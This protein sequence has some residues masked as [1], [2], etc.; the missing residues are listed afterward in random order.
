MI[1]IRPRRSALYMPGS[2]ARAIEKARTL[3]A[4]VVIFDL[5]DAVAPDLK[6]QAREQVCAA[7]K[8]GGYGRRELVIRVNALETPWGEADLAAAVA[9]APDAILVPKVSS[10]ETLAAVGLRLRKLGAA[11]R[12]GIWAMIE[13]PLAILRAESIASAAH[14][15]D[16]RLS[17]F[18]MGTNDLAK[19]TRTRLLPGR[20]AMLPWLMTALAAA[21]A[22][23]IDILDGVYNTLS[24]ESGFRAE[25]EQGRDCGFDGKTLIHPD[26]IAA[27]NGIF[28]P[29]E[30]E[31]ESARTIVAAF[32]QPENRARGAISLGGRMVERLHAEMARR[33]L[34]MAEAIAKQTT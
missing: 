5:E 10:A 16:T 19:D 8:A 17:C 4:D 20:A 26:Q 12:T 22:H 21:R 7:V 18:V 30:H 1:P 23:G 29:S 25:C 2:N 15:V 3:A 6:T 32:E 14:D 13:T 9:A 34:A 31:I 11:E 27:A 28:A 33:T 24:D